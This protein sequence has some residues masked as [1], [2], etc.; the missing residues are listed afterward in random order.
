MIAMRDHRFV[1]RLVREERRAEQVI[2]QLRSLDSVCDGGE[3]SE[4][5][6]AIQVASRAERA[7]ADDE[8]VLAALLHD[9]GKVFGDVGHAE[10]SADVLAPHIRPEVVEVVRNHCAFTARHWNEIPEG[11]SDP[12]NVF[13]DQA[14]FELARQF[15]D[16]WDM[17]SFDP[18]YESLPL[19]HFEPLVQRFVTGP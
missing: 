10:I 19:A 6:H 11:A 9:I 5:N 13:T 12:R 7:G 16:E 14:W 2:A 15:V 17:Q 18:N 1:E 4:L 8:V 3:I